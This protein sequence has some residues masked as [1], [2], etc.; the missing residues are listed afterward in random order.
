MRSSF[1]Y[2]QTRLQARHGMRA[3]ERSWQLAE[4]Q[5]ELGNFLQSAR[6]TGLKHWVSGLQATDPHQLLETGI[7]T[8]YRDYIDDIASW[9]PPDWRASVQWTK[10]LTYLPALLHLLKGNTA[11][12]WMLQD[13]VLKPFTGIHHEQRDAAFL[14][15]ELA[16]L[17]H[18]RHEGLSLIAAWT[19]RW[20]ALWPDLRASE[21]ASLQLLYRLLQQHL[22]AFTQAAPATAWPQRQQLAGRLGVMFRQFRYQP[23]AIF[24]HLLLVALDVERL[25]GGILQRQLFP[26]FR[27]NGA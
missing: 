21:R 19:T 18:A 24:A 25:R 11:Q 27:E 20:Q 9:T 23:A 1:I 14:Q 3:D 10:L 8:L 15:S 2:T 16:L 13:P 12:A 26:H 7:L 5:R 4:S 17:M 6:Q 22:E